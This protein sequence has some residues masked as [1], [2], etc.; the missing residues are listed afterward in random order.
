MTNAAPKITMEIGITIAQNTQKER[1]TSMP[2]SENSKKLE[3]NNVWVDQR[4]LPRAPK[5]GADIPTQIFR[6]GRPLR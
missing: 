2:L 5:V 3:L 4:E 1:V 6:E